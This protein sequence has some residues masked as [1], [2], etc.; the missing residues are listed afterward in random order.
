M[1]CGLQ[2]HNFNVS[3]CSFCDFI[4]A[5][6]TVVIAAPTGGYRLSA[7]EKWANMYGARRWPT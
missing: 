4:N 6:K 5:L 7:S 3:V 2:S 1:V